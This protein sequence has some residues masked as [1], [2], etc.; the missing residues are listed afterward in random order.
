MAHIREGSDALEA[1]IQALEDL[2]AI[3]RLKHSYFRCLDMRLWDE[4]RGYFVR[5]ATVDYGGQYKFDGADT[6][7][8][9]LS[10][11][12]GEKSGSHGIHMGGHRTP[13]DSA[14]TARGKWVLWTFCQPGR[15]ERGIG[16]NNTTIRQG[17]QRPGDQAHRYR[18]LPRGMSL[19]DTRDSGCPP[20]GCAFSSLL[21]RPGGAAAHGHR[22]YAEILDDATSG[23][24]PS[25]RGWLPHRR[26]RRRPRWH[27]DAARGAGD[28]R[29][30]AYVRPGRASSPTAG[31]ARRGGRRGQRRGFDA[32]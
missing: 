24:R 22:S 26:P 6:I 9:F 15:T 3:K 4:L 28:L 30:R 29:A 12:L 25:P 31:P 7:I 1:R 14:T 5:D 19:A 32:R 17:G 8:H 2:E 16:A 10:E 20:G 27:A 23:S 21:P 18:S 11:S 13:A